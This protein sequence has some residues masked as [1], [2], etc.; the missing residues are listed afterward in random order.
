[1]ALDPKL[2]EVV[3]AVDLGSNSFHL[4]VAR[5][6]DGAPAVVDRLREMVQLASGLGQSG[7]LTREARQRAIDC[8]RRFG[9]RVSHMPA[10]AVRVVGTNTL[11]S[12]R[13][14]EEFLLEAEQAIGHPI[15]TISGIEEARLIYVGVTH[16]LPGPDL[17]RLVVDIGG[18]STEL[19]VGQGLRPSV[20]ESL[21]MGCITSSR[22]HFPDGALTSKNWRRAETAARQELEPVRERFRRARWREAVGASGTI[23]AIDTLV[24]THGWGKDGITPASVGRLREALLKA[25]SIDKL[26]LEGLNPKRRP[27]LAGGAVILGV[28][29]DALEIEHLQRSDVALREGLIYDL[30]GRIRDRDVRQRSV[31]TLADRYHVD[32]R[33]AARVECTAL[34]L[35]SQ[36]VDDWRLA[37]PQAR[38]LLAWSA[39]LH[40]VGLDVAHDHYHWHGEYIAAHSDLLG[41]SRHEQYLLA[42]LVRAHRRKFPSSVI[43][44]LPRGSQRTIERLA[45]LLRLAVILHRSRSPDP[46][47][48]IKLAV[49]KKSIEMRFP[50]G[51]LDRHPL[52][53]AD[54]ETEASYLEAGAYGLDVA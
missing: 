42:T 29:M 19:V 7:R 53:L 50:D 17:R 44:E 47:P 51:W 4:I 22:A 24:G 37:S 39:Q 15:E 3:A 34:R 54:L 9:E 49:S 46:L 18:G 33:H 32:W 40:E 23:R 6:D 28:V 21:Y 16:S 30:I 31:E 20:M 13:N 25:G 11:R 1:M 14:T 48:E 52:T 41:F 45:I 26:R 43:R 27:F 35:L 8:L 5:T 10:G 2:P 36:V 38:K 12:A